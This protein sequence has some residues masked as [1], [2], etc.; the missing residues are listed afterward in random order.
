NDV[1]T[2][3]VPEKLARRKRSLVTTKAI[4][5]NFVGFVIVPSKGAANLYT[6]KIKKFYFHET[7]RSMCRS[8]GDVRRYIFEGF[9]NLKVDVQLETIVLIESK[10]GVIEKKLKKIKGESS[11]S[12]RESAAKKRKRNGH[13]NPNKSETQKILDDAWNN[14]MNMD[15]LRNNH[16]THVKTTITN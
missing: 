5:N 9:E 11:I 10:V 14:L 16:V 6:I 13:D 7:K 8:I 3:S 15:D 2:I 12:E 4:E 1:E